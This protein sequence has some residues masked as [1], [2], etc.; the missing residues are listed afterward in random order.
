[1]DEDLRGRV[2][3]FYSMSFI[4]FTPV[5]SLILGY[6]ADQAGVS[7]TFTFAAGMLLT[8]SLLFS[9]SFNSIRE[10]LQLG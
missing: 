10:N 8:A 9:R 3:S 7:L 1:V 2:L 4:G 6:I 5:G